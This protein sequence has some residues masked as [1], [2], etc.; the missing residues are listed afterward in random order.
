M[1]SSSEDPTVLRPSWMTVFR[2]RDSKRK[3]KL[4]LASFSA[5]A[6]FRLPLWLCCTYVSAV[7]LLGFFVAPLVSLRY[8]AA[9]R[10][11]GVSTRRSERGHFRCIAVAESCRLF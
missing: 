6:V 9:V 1:D 7:L 8:N 3:R 4:L 10:T 2:T 5:P 11:R